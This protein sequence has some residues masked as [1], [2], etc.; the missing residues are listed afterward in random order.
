M[1]LPNS[2]G[3]VIKLSG[4][5]R[6]PYAVRI[7]VGYEEYQ[8]NKFRQKFK[9]LE[10]FRTSKEA[11]AY[12]AER[13]AGAA[14]PEHQNFTE[15]PTFSEVYKKWLDHKLSMKKPPTKATVRNYDIAYR[16][17]SALHNR[18]FNTIRTGDI[19]PIATSINDKSEATVTM[20]KTVLSQMYEYSIKQ[21]W[22][23]KNYA[24]L[25]DWE[26][27]E[28]EEQMHAPFTDAEIKTLWANKDGQFVDMVLILI[29]T[30]LRASEFLSLEIKNINLEEHYMIGGMKTAA[31]T[32][33]TIPIHDAVLPLIRR[34]YDE[35]NKY[36]FTSTRGTS[37]PYTT[38]KNN[39]WRPVMKRLGM[40]HTAHDTRHTFATL[41]N[42]Y[43]LDDF[44]VKLMMG[45]STGD[46]TKDVYTHVTPA[47]LV[48]EVNKIE[49]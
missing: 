21:E 13:N 18:K 2:Y 29:Y 42:R 6:K 34:Y 10:Y 9:Y 7:T 17:F 46:L 23:D 49:I 30:G 45:H 26:Y 36:L 32:N 4:K 27:T 11:Y 24:A 44:K 8:P 28:S 3:S 12:L 22:V 35:N 47:E 5:R 37:L 31:G 20:A 43:Q 1:K 33:R 16:R 15:M 39:K 41:A 25:C 38:F 14:V 40:E 19:Q 48:K